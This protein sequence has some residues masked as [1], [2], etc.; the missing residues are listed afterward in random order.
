MDA[1][2]PW[3]RRFLLIRAPTVKPPTA[4]RAISEY[5]SSGSSTP[6]LR[7]SLAR[8]PDSNRFRRGSTGFHPPTTLPA[9]RAEAHG[10]PDATEAEVGGGAPIHAELALPVVSDGGG[11][12]LATICRVCTLLPA[13]RAVAT[14]AIPPS[15]PI[16]PT[17]D[18]ANKASPLI[19]LN[20]KMPTRAV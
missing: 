16:R 3:R 4:I 12:T 11:V 5:A 1:Q 20:I 15:D 13:G 8:M 17:V 14:T 6:T 19:P 2:R 7:A 9:V 10:I 18:E